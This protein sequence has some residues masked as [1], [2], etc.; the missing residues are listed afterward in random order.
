MEKEPSKHKKKTTAIQ[1][2]R[3]LKS[4]KDSSATSL[5]LTPNSYSSKYS[6]FSEDKLF[7]TPRKTDNAFLTKT[8]LGVPNI[9]QN[10]L[11]YLENFFASK[12]FQNTLNDTKTFR[13]FLCFVEDDMSSILSQSVTESIINTFPNIPKEAYLAC[14]L[15]RQQIQRF[16]HLVFQYNKMPHFFDEEPNL[17]QGGYTNQCQFSIQHYR[18][19]T[20]WY[21][22]DPLH[23]VTVNFQQRYFPFSS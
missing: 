23:L 21:I 16:Q 9:L 2:P 20:T 18:F 5:P 17:F 14:N 15:N 12:A 11:R 22:L 4:K 3:D 6:S 8:F 19:N 1:S 13:D 7:E 10:S